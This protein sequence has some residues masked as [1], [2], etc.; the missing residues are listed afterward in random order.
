[1]LKFA[2][3]EIT[4]RKDFKQKSDLILKK[5]SEWYFTKSENVGANNTFLLDE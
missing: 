5:I 1:M 4:E 3:D 2:N